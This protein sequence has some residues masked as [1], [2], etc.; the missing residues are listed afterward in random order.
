MFAR[1]LNKDII[2]DE[3]LKEAYIE[4]D[5]SLDTD[6]IVESAKVL[7]GFLETL[8]TLQLKTVDSEYI[9]SIFS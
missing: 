8:N 2:R 3:H 5:G 7:Y 6:T 4:E 1:Q 9:K